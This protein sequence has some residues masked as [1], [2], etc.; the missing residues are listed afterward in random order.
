MVWNMTGRGKI[1]VERVDHIGIRVRALDRALAFYNV[2]GL[3]LTR[4]ASKDAVAIIANDADVEINLVV[5]ANAGDERENILMD[6]AGKFPGITH[7]ALRV[8]SIAETIAALEAH[9]IA[10]AQGPV[11]F[12]QDN[13][14][15]VF[16][17]D[18]DRNVVELRGRGQDLSAIEG[19]A[20]YLSE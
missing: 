11:R 7:V 20:Q 17:R 3:E 1:A 10:I 4:V 5:N 18:P 9:G 8:T 13:G 16:I 14:V 12:G 2:L 6:V 15:S 19:V